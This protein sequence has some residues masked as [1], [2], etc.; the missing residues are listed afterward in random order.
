MTTSRDSYIDAIELVLR[1][2]GNADKARNMKAY[3]LNQF[4]F[5]GISAPARR[6]AV[7][8]RGM[9]SQ[10]WQSAAELLAVANTL[11]QKPER[12]FRYTAVDL[13]KANVKTLDLSDAEALIEL[14]RIDPWWDTV[15]SM[16][17][18]IGLIVFNQIKTG[19]AKAQLICDQWVADRNFWVR[20]C[21]M[22]H[23]L[24]WRLKSDK[25]L[26]YQYAKALG[27][28]RGFFIKKALGWSLRDYARWD[29]DWVKLVLA[30]KSIELSALTVREASKYLR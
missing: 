17:S 18:V 12:E 8:G 10:K 26:L 7:K 20:R 2:L 21:A 13:L 15:D 16:T 11:W 4:D 19:N 28:E 30:D 29:P 14:M 22:L 27:A 9:H 1:P 23:Q 25:N 6:A 5:I 24:S 3:L